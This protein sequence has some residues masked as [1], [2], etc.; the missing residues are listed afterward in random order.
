[1]SLIACRSACQTTI[2]SDRC[3]SF[4]GGRPIRDQRLNRTNR[5]RESSSSTRES[6]RTTPPRIPRNIKPKR[7]IRSFPRAS[8]DQ[9][10]RH[11]ELGMTAKFRNVCATLRRRW[12]RC[13]IRLFISDA[14]LK[15][16]C[17]DVKTRVS[18]LDTV[19]LI[20]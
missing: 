18:F 19:Y 5:A 10:L 20:L 17:R 6:W 8:H 9:L 1:M 11:K 14:I 15:T 4:T 3:D 13:T 7:T 16:T 12:H 2:C